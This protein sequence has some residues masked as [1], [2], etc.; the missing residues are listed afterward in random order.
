[1]SL[2]NVSLYGQDT[3]APVPRLTLT[4]GL[5]WEVDGYPSEK[6]NNYPLAVSGLNNPSALTF[7]P[8]VT[9]LWKTTYGNVAPRVEAAYQLS[10]DPGHET[11]LRGGAGVFYDLPYGF[12][13]QSFASS[14]PSVV[15]AP[16]PVGTA[17]PLNATTAAPPSLNPAPPAGVLFVTDPNLQLPYVYEWNV[18]AER[19]L[20]TNQAVSASYVGAAG[21]RL[22]RSEQLQNT[23][24]NFTTLFITRNTATSDYLGLQ[25]QYRRRLSGGLQALASYTWSDSNDDASNDFVSTAPAARIDP[26]Q[27]QG[28]SDFDAH[29]VFSALVSYDLPSSP[30]AGLARTIGRGWSVDSILT[31]RSAMPV[32]VFTTT[33]VLG[34]GISSIS[35]P[36]VVPGLPLYVNDPTAPGGMR[37]NS[38]AF[39]IPPANAG[40]QGTLTRNALRGFPAWQVDLA[41]RRRV[42]L[43]G[44][45]NAEFRVEVFDVFNHPNFANP[46]G[47]LG[48]NAIPNAL[49]GQATQMLGRSLGSGGIGGGLNPLYQTGGPRSAQLAVKIHF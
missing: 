34:L 33:D 48:T 42:E 24:A 5:R 47:N 32:N 20:G 12:A 45:V 36:D 3:W 9:P 23:N 26:R 1:M 31:A 18:S 27:D 19:S 28:P 46:Q 49:F 14:W 10:G 21:R 2:N 35:R 16:I 38:A 41:L 22:L 6:N 39:S 40:R 43:T 17:F 29:H 15:R 4:Y 44:Q 13:L 11:V 37:I 8:P 7:A 25:L 30:G